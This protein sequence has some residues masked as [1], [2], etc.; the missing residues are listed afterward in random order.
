MTCSG[1]CHRSVLLDAEMSSVT[2]EIILEN[3]SGPK[4][5]KNCVKDAKEINMHFV[6]HEELS[7]IF[8]KKEYLHRERL[9]K[10]MAQT[11][12]FETGVAKEKSGGGG[13]FVWGQSVRRSG[14]AQSG[15]PGP[16]RGSR[17]GLVSHFARLSS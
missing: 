14:V 1:N 4:L 11:L 6:R 12:N 8:L 13:R 7:Y 17:A 16:G 2:E 15:R 5:P 9:A 3:S 10:A